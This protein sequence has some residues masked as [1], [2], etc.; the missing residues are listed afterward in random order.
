MIGVYRILFK[1]SFSGYARAGASHSE[2]LGISSIA[3]HRHPLLVGSVEPTS[4]NTV[5][6]CHGV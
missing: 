4:Q 1:L 5:G 6:G 2:E 3:Q